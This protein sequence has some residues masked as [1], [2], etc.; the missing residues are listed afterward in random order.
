M[1]TPHVRWEKVF[2]TRWELG[3]EAGLPGMVGADVKRELLLTGWFDLAVAPGFTAGWYE[4]PLV[5]GHVPLVAD[6]IL[7]DWLVLV[8]HLSPG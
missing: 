7:T 1:P 2:A 8:S 6:L 4:R 3:I 5:E